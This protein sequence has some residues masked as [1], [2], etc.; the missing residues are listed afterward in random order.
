MIETLKGIFFTG[1]KIGRTSSVHQEIETTESGAYFS[2]GDSYIY[3]TEYKVWY[4]LGMP[5][6]GKTLKKWHELYE[7]ENL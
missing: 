6:W 2:S 5:C 4:F 3:H 1:T 7:K